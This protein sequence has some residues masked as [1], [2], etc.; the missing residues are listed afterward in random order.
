L[1][2]ARRGFV[3]L[4]IGTPDRLN[5]PRSKRASYSPMAAA[6]PRID[7]RWRSWRTPPRAATRGGPPEHPMR[8]SAPSECDWPLVRR[9]MV[10][11]R[12]VPA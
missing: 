10:D 9:Q 8:R 2:L 7:N 3:T 12:F 5:S 1:R 11:V 4:S 6:H